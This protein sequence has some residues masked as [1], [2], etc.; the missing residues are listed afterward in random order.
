MRGH[1]KGVGVQ[2]QENWSHGYI[3]I[4][5]LNLNRNGAIIK[6]LA[7]D[8]H[9]WR[10]FTCQLQELNR[11]FLA[12]CLL[13]SL[14]VCCVQCHVYLDTLKHIKVPVSIAIQNGYVWLDVFG[15]YLSDREK[16]KRAKQ[17]TN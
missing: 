2:S 3:Y 7:L 5:L 11:L 14:L 1:T 10:E 8:M 12:L 15:G 16:S 17:S 13:F 4:F 9:I 6:I